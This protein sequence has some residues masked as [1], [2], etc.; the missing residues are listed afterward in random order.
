MRL[1]GIATMPI[2]TT[3]LT[4][5]AYGVAA[6]AGTIISLVSVI[7]LAGIEMSY[8]RAYY[9]AQPPS[10]ATVEHYCWRFAILGALLAAVSQ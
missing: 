8:A 5:Q 2:L 7:G 9:S 1:L 6:L 4:P 3:W 10:G